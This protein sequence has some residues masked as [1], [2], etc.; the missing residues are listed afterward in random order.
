M[1]A[2]LGTVSMTFRLSQ[3]LCSSVLERHV[4]IICLSLQLLAQQG[5]HVHAESICLKL[6]TDQLSLQ[7]THILLDSKFFYT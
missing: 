4:S 1:R 7:Q 3:G 6:H 5:R 2:S